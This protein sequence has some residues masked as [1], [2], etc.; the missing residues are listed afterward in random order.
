MSFDQL[1]LITFVKRNNQEKER[2]L[3]LEREGGEGRGGESEAWTVPWWWVSCSVQLG[4]R[5]WICLWH[6]TVLV[7]PCPS[8]YRG[9]GCRRRVCVCER[10]M[11]SPYNQTGAADASP[12]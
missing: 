5:S 4:S 6:G 7:M 3:A 2:Y 12:V 10:E 9:N 8:I 1:L 11:Q